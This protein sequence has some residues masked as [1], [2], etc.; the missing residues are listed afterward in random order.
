MDEN[1]IHRRASHRIAIMVSSKTCLLYWH[2]AQI[3]TRWIAH[4]VY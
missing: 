3:T 1:I 2:I 4:E